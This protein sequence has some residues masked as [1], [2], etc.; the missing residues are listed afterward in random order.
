MMEAFLA[1]LKI[2]TKISTAAGLLILPLFYLAIHFYQKSAEDINSTKLELA[3]LSYIT[4]MQRMLGELM[5]RRGYVAGHGI[6]TDAS[7]DFRIEN[8]N[9]RKNLAELDQANEK[10]GLSLDIKAEFM[11]FRSAVATVLETPLNAERQPHLEKHYEAIR[12]L[13]SL[14]R[15]IMDKASLDMESESGA[16]YLIELALK[17]ISPASEIIGQVRYLANGYLS[18][19]NRNPATLLRIEERFGVI[20]YQRKLIENDFARIHKYLPEKKDIFDRLLSEQQKLWEAYAALHRKYFETRIGGTTQRDGL[21]YANAARAFKESLLKIA[22]EAVATTRTKFEQRVTTLRMKQ[23][24]ILGLA[25]GLAAISGVIGWYI[26]RQISTSLTKA[27]TVSENLAAG[28]LDFTVES[29]GRGEIGALMNSL[30]IMSQRLKS[31]LQQVHQSASEISLAAQQVA[32]TAEMLNNGAMDQAAHV[33]ETGAA[34]GEMV[35]L[36]GSNAKNAVETDKA[37]RGA[38]NVTE[39]GAENIMSAVQSMKNISERIQIV[40]EIASQT[41]LLALNA[42]I[43]AARAGEHGRGFA[44]VATEVGKLADTSGQA[45]K[46]IQA[47]L[48]ESSLVSEN[49]AS[50][51]GLITTNMQDTAEKVLAIRKASEEQD[52]A[53]KQISESMGR[54]N[55]TTEQTASAAEELAATAEEM[56]SQTATLIENLKF[57]RFA[58]D[59]T[60]VSAQYSAANAIRRMAGKTAPKAPPMPAKKTSTDEFIVS[61]GQYEKF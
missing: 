32:S 28:N 29:D 6:N 41:N 44:V 36:I 54:L 53:A 55:Q 57:F 33:E 61:S 40:Q 37:A 20:E 50:S 13:L 56:S 14:Q 47:L 3:G 60:S 23:I 45:A 17:T 7:T 1:G 52:H 30:Q 39:T 22:L 5:L 10:Y 58:A 8:E 24:S 42:T 19:D 15:D 48:K 26:L 16:F 18:G 9:I 59:D 25:F 12:G 27:M 2:R 38:V 51:L 34:L 46:Q 21:A 43:E 49:A 4:P 11:R 35:N 31:V